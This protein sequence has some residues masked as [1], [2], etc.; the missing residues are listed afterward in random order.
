[1][2]ITDVRVRKI[3]KEDILREAGYNAGD[4]GWVYV[5]YGEEYGWVKV[6]NQNDDKLNIESHTNLLEKPVIYLYPETETGGDTYDKVFLLSIREVME[7]FVNEDESVA[8]FCTK[9]QNS[10]TDDNRSDWWLRSCG[11]NNHMQAS[12]SSAGRINCK[13]DNVYYSID[14]SAN[15]KSQRTFLTI[16]DHLLW[17]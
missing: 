2:Q 9:L 16:G 4:D 1:M 8:S 12:V 15:D 5:R 7:F 10:D 14:E 11:E 6:Y 17:T 3:A 13:G